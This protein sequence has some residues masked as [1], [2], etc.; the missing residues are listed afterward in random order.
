MCVLFVCFFITEMEC[1]QISMYFLQ[2]AHG[3]LLTEMEKRAN[4]VRFGK[5]PKEHGQGTKRKVS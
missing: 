5:K 1:R 3:R 4:S 2:F